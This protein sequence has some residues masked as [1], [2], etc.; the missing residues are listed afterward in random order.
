MEHS[1]HL[2]CKFLFF[3]PDYKSE[4]LKKIKIKVNPTSFEE[5]RMIQQ[6]EG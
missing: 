3:F 2:I 5:F 6:V 1:R 4:S